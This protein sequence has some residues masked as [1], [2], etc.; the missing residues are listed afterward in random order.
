MNPT[1]ERQPFC[2]EL[3]RAIG[4]NV[5]NFQ[6]LEAT[7]RSMIPALSNHGTATEWQ[8]RH[9]RVT[10]KHM[11]SSL[12]DLADVFHDCVFSQPADADTLTDEVLSEPSMSFAFRLEATPESVAQQKRA[13]AT[14]APCGDKIR[15][16]RRNLDSASPRTR[17][18]AAETTLSLCCFE[19]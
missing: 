3:L 5:V 18:W 14:L 15:Q 13:L 1:P 4:R 16:A 9:L 19:V 2:D 8:A 10:R 7:L 12:G 17:K 6:Y 11:K